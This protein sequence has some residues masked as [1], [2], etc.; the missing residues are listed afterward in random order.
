MAALS[1]RA[2]I[3]PSNTYIVLELRC[4]VRGSTNPT[5]RAPQRCDMV[6]SP[7]GQAPRPFQNLFYSVYIAMLASSFHQ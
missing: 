5:V 1:L 4:R 3:L 7:I 2:F 6:R